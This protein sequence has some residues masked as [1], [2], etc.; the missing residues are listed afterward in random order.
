MYLNRNPAKYYRNKD[1]LT[2]ISSKV[3]LGNLNKSDCR[4]VLLFIAYKDIVKT[5]YKIMFIVYKL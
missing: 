4:K 1:F 3:F 5:N 2:L